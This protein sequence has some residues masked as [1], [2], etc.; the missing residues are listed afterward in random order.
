MSPSGTDPE[1][2]QIQLFEAPGIEATPELEK[3]VDK[4]FSRQEFRRASFADLGDLS[5]PSRAA[6]SYVDDLLQ[7]LDVE[8]I[9]KRAFRIVVDYSYSSASL[10]LP[11]VLGALE[12]ETIASHT[13]LT[14]RTEA[15]P[16]A[17]LQESFGQVKRLVDRRRRRLRGRHRPGRR[18]DLPRGRAG[19]RGPRRARAP[20]LP[21]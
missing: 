21:R 18:A 15:A 12:V 19:A 5:F 20:A 3:E 2:V 9:R 10:I 4:H 8:A 13:Y 16:A 6:E 7:T 17:S 1:V 14:G 11:I